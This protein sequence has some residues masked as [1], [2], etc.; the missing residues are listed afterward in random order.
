MASRPRTVKFSPDLDEAMDILAV[1]LGYGNRN[2]LMKG[3]ARFACLVEGKHDTTLPWS[4]LSPS[5]QDKIDAHCLAIVKSGIGQRGQLLRHI[6]E[7]VANG[8]S[9]EDS[10]AR[11]AAKRKPDA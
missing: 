7:D 2:A 11:I 4:K 5:E 6:V 8:I 9:A 3:L 10:L 1:R